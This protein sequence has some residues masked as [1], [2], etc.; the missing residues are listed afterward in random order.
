MLLAGV[1]GY[2]GD[3]RWAAAKRLGYL[4]LRKRTATALRAAR[5]AE[6]VV[7]VVVVTT[8]A[9]HL[10]G[11]RLAGRHSRGADVGSRAPGCPL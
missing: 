4:L 3:G 10:A 5:P 9:S 1:G 11:S 6:L 7:V 2:A 8:W